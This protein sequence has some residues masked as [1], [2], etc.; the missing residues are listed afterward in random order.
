[1]KTFNHKSS[2]LPPHEADWNEQQL[3]QLKRHLADV[4][5]P[6]ST[7]YRRMFE[8]LGLK[9][10]DIHSWEDW[11]SVPFTTKDDLVSTKAN[12]DAIRDFL[13][14]P[15]QK[16]LA[17]RPSTILRTLLHGPG[18][19][20]RSFEREFRHIFLTSTT[21]RS[22]EPIPFLY[23]QYDLDLL[24][25]TGR[26]VFETCG[27]SREMRL[28]NLFPFAPHLAFWLT[29]YGAADFG[30]FTASTGGGKVMGTEGC[31]RMMRKIKP[32]VIIGMPTFIYHVLHQAVEEGVR[33]EKLRRIVLGGEKV[34]HGMR[35]KLDALAREAGS[36]GVE[37]LGTYG[38][39]EART[40]WAECPFPVDEQS[41]G[42]HL[43]PEFGLIEIINPK[44]GEVL[45]PGLPGEIVFTPL[46]GRGTVVLRYRTGDFV[47]GGLTYEPCPR[48]GRTVP[49]LIG[50]ISRASEIRSLHIDKLKGTLVDFNQL[51]H[52]LDDTP[53]IGAWQIE[54]R[55]HHDDPLDTDELVLHV[56]K[57]NGADE[58]VI[59]A[60]IQRRFAS[61]MELRLN[62]IEFHDAD[63]MRRLQGVGTELKELRLVDHRPKEGATGTVPL[64]TGTKLT[65][66]SISTSTQAALRVAE[67]E[68]ATP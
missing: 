48:C 60:S 49:R 4:V 1:M 27:A 15:D 50:N 58:Q 42:Y 57:L 51:E 68:E 44:T 2:F 45:P 25:E 33:C 12:P 61:R 35:R 56:N 21:G 7:H 19:V 24:A 62:R 18:K 16:V 13:L 55:K 29:H 20:C 65:S 6:F 43:H 17:R 28:L 11:S 64:V 8:T 10:A 31:L 52:V 38:F 5:V 14:L 22:A 40:A 39:T 34:P 47:D 59:A 37:V 36:A 46:D 23:T 67:L 53:Q 41:S 66:Q 9:A 30:V 26:R 3:R 54:I 63:E 32:D